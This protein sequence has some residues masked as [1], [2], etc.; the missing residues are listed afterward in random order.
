[1]TAQDPP[2]NGNDDNAPVNTP[3]DT[4][5][6]TP[7][8][9]PAEAPS[10]TPALE[11]RSVTRHYQ[12]RVE[13]VRA[14]TDANLVLHGGSLTALIGPSG[15]GKTTLVNLIVGWEEPDSG[16]VL[17]PSRSN[18]SDLAVVPQGI[19]LIE[20]L[21]IRENIDLP[22]RLGT[23][24]QATAAELMEQLGLS[25]LSDRRPYEI[26]L[27]EQQRAAIARSMVGQPRVLVA[28]E[29]T[30]HQDEANADR[31]FSMLQRA[32]AAGSAVIIATHETRLLERAD[33]VIRME[34]GSLIEGAG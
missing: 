5:P 29:P 1:M 23:P 8:D 18:W 11:L 16:E 7:S 19:G 22:L 26:S 34:H 27:G 28:D 25:E 4:P 14:V 33:R 13:T 30:A 32:A 31:I 24:G 2:V 3:G 21:T 10:D 15:S 20:D 6:N 17:M 12:G 9:T